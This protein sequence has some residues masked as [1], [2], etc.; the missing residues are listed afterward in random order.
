MILALLPALIWLII[1]YKKD[2]SQ[3]EPKKLI[4][5]S[6][7]FG[8]LGIMPFLGINFALNRAD[9]LQE[10]WVI[11]TKKTFFISTIFLTLIL[12]FLEES[13]KHFS[14]LRLGKSLKVYFDQI[15][16]G[17]IYS[18]SAALGFAFAENVF[19][20]LEAFFALG[21]SVDFLKVFLFRSFG[22]MFAH[23]IF[24]G[25]F[26]FFWSFAFLSKKIT[27]HHNISVSLM[28]KKITE[29][30]RFHIIFSHIL[31]GRTSTRGHEKRE[32]VAEA[33]LLATLLHAVFNLLI[34]TEIFGHSLTFLVVPILMG[35]FLY[36]SKKFLENK[37]LKIWKK[38]L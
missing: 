13:I 24:S 32:L 33:L 6:F 22:T 15:V 8:V 19:Y 34:K 2:S 38:P 4:F 11:F 31:K 9:A 18:V 29:T 26:G 35:G 1:W 20:F 12:A 30:I 21:I 17:I 28:W 3:P 36:L 23:T 7:I 25:L 16:D 14:V 37:N 5:R 27:P 10:I